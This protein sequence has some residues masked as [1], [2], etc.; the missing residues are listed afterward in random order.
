MQQ[1]QP[2]EKYPLASK[3][4]VTPI[5]MPPRQ[6]KDQTADLYFQNR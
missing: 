4:E 1:I 6:T 5:T 2:I 3:Y